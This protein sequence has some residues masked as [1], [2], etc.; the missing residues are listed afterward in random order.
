[1]S[2]TI[3]TSFSISEGLFE[4]LDSHFD[5]ITPWSEQD[6]PTL[7]L[8]FQDGKMELQ[9]FLTQAEAREAAEEVRLFPGMYLEVWDPEVLDKAIFSRE[10]G[11]KEEEDWMWEEREFSRREE[12]PWIKE[13]WTTGHPSLGLGWL[14]F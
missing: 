4:A 2:K 3:S 6:A 12:K 13:Y 11:R 9:H 7:A 14:G 1:M 8:F 10:A 5:A